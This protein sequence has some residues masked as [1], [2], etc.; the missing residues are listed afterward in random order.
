[1][2]EFVARVAANM[3]RWVCPNDRQL[4]LRAKLGTGWSVHTNKQAQFKKSD[5]LSCEEQE[6][7][8]N[9]IQKAD[10]LEQ[11]EQ[12]RIGHL[13]EKL[14]NMRKNAIGNGTTQCILC[15][16][17]FGLLGASP[18]YCDDCKKAVCTKC[19]ID[20]Y[21]CNHQPLWLCKICSEK[22]ELW[23]RSGAWFFK[24]IPKYIYPSKRGAG[25]GKA[26]R[27]KAGD[28]VKSN[29]GGSGRTYN[30]WSKARNKPSYGESS[31]QESDE[32]EDDVSIG[33]KKNKNSESVDSDSISITSSRSNNNPL[34]TGHGLAD[35]KSSIT[36][37][38]LYGQLS[39]TESSRGDEVHDE[40]DSEKSSS[41]G[42]FSREGSLRSNY[43]TSGV[44]YH[45]GE[46]GDIDAAF[47]RYTS[48]HGPHG[49]TRHHHH[50][51]TQPPPQQPVEEYE[52]DLP[53][54]PDSEGT[55]LGTL[56]FSLLYDAFDNAL[57]CTIVRARGLKAMD[58][59][60]LSDP[61]VKLHLLPRASKSKLRTKTIHKTLNPEWNE[62]LTYY[63][64][65]EEDHIR[66]TLRL[67]V[68]DEDTFGYDFIGETRVPLKRLKPDQ[69][70]NFNV[71]LEKQLPME[72]DDEL[73]AHERGKIA[74]SLCYNS[75]KGGLVVGIIRCADLA[76]MD[77]NGYSDPYVKV[78]LRPD[79]D[80][81]TKNKTATKKKTLNPEFNEEFFYDVKLTDLAKKTLEVTVWDKD[82]GKANDY[83]G[84]LQLGINAKGDRLKH[85]FECLKTPDKKSERWHSLSAE[86]MA[87]SPT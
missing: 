18:T 43:E 61:Y 44:R 64:V 87:V 23:K 56:E 57:N 20:T 74:V 60:G 12:E 70:K 14:E 48:Q 55:S 34:Y 54:S 28:A 31:D 39:A 47:T 49:Q 16:D 41:M 1:M 13:V 30:T 9:V 4:A 27:M 53:S 25:Y 58:S 19:G 26:G 62:T 80:R 11:V 66:K 5:N 69:T 37:S 51:P 21:N 38:N 86:V 85:W 17:E 24:G 68:L 83:I 73:M 10:M 3:D 76:A 29:R 84:G 22:R 71:Y 2:G 45:T 35:S 59:N 79:R 32:S 72:K 81:K 33:K 67:S 46:E 8:M 7:I 82:I 36:S 15:G 65:T 75:R 42:G 63:G 77:S 6:Q 50:Q 78:Y 52:A 40:T